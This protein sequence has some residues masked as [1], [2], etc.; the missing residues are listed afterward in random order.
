M[1]IE[2][3]DSKS[4]VSE[5]ERTIDMEKSIAVDTTLRLM[6]GDEK[7]FGPGLAQL[8]EG[9]VVYGSLRRSAAEMNMSY[10]K[11]WKIVKNS[12]AQWGQALIERK[13]GGVRGGG[14][15]LTA[16]GQSL[17]TKYRAFEHKAQTTLNALAQE[18]F[19]GV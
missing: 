1:R 12:E 7:A 18:Y 17:L 8:L 13:I 9:I 5:I 2:W 19:E 16:F 3:I 4:T 10:N 14:A 6:Y 11:A 15:V